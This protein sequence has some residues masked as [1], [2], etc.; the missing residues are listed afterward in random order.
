MNEIVNNFF[1]TKDTFMSKMHLEKSG[2]TYSA[3]VA[4]AKNEE[5]N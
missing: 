4:F 5:R 1:L 2:F 3:F